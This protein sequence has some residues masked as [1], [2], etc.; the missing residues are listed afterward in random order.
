VS[1]LLQSHFEILHRAHQHVHT[2]LFYALT[3]LSVANLKKK[4][5]HKLW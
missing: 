2:E 5:E 3:L 1:N 4:E